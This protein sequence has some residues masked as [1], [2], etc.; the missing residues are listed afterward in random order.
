[1]AV[2]CY[3][4]MSVVMTARWKLGESQ[5]NKMFLCLAIAAS[6]LTGACTRLTIT[7]GVL[8]NGTPIAAIETQGDGVSP[9][10]T[11]IVALGP[12]GQVAPINTAASEGVVPSALKGAVAGIAVGAGTAG[13]GALLRPSTT[14]IANT[15]AANASPVN[16]NS[17]RARGGNGGTGLG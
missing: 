1:M 14:N 8:S 5:M 3:H 12:T 7:E 17:A 16:I 15:S 11:T 10:T 9:P 4:C 13:A 2:L 6:V